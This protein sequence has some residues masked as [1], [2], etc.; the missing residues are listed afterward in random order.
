MIAR[1]PSPNGVEIAAMVSS[2]MAELAGQGAVSTGKAA[3]NLLRALITSGPSDCQRCQ[4]IWSFWTSKGQPL[5][6]L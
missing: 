6:C 3:E 2:S 5:L 1:P 4:R